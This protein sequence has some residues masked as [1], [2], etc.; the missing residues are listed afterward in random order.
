[1]LKADYGLD[2]P[3]DLQIEFSKRVQEITERTG[4]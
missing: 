4:K 2:L 1:V 3:R